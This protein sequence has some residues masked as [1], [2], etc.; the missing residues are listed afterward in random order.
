MNWGHASAPLGLDLGMREGVKRMFF[1]HHDPAASD[2]KIAKIELQ[3]REYYDSVIATYTKQKQ[4]A[5]IVEWCFAQEGMVI[6]V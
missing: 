6:E 4:P 5:P 3:T 1:I 2:A